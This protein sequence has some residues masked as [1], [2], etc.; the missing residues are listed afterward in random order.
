MDPT[1]QTT[2]ATL[3]RFKK[4]TMEPLAAIPCKSGAPVLLSGPMP[5]TASLLTKARRLRME[6]TTWVKNGAK[7]V[8]GSVRKERLATC[9]TCSFWL[10]E[11][12][13][14][15]GECRH[16]SCGCTRAK[17]ALATSKCPIGKWTA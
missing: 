11:G 1:A 7:L 10:E 15:L 8:P 14:G 3:I 12:N 4:G 6:L 9:R 17:A 2:Q 16:G 5:A 13:W